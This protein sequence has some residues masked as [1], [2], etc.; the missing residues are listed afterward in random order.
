[1]RKWHGTSTS[2][3]PDLKALYMASLTLTRMAEGGIYDQLGGGFSRYSVDGQWM[4]PHFEKMLYDNG[5]LLCEFARA[6]LATGEAIFARIAGDTADW[7]LRDMRS[8][9]GGFYSSLDADSE[10][11]EGRFYVW[12]RA[13]VEALLTPQEYAAF[14]RRFGLDRSANFEGEWHLH[15]YESIDAVAAVLGEPA[16]AVAALIASAQAKLLEVREL[17]GWPARAEKILTA[18]NAL[19]ITGLLSSARVLHRPDL[20]D[21]ATAAVDF[22]RHSP[23]PDRPLL[24][25]YK[26][27][28][29]HLPAYLDHYPFLAD[30]LLQLLQTRSP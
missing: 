2:T 15:T 25:T 13:E 24:S 11:H 6:S 17:R 23:W 8:P 22:I 26:D 18:W 7:V 3:S 4:I 16:Q 10:G 14:A 29:A 27:G 1:M 28:R 12:T 19:H 20:A 9:H 21:A 30:A 5:Q